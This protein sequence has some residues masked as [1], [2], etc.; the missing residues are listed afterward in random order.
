MSFIYTSSIEVA[1]PNPRGDPIINGNEDT[2]YTPSLKFPYS[3]TKK[4]AE[5]AVLHAQGEVLQNGGRLATCALRPMFIYGEG[6]P[7]LLHSMVKGI[8]NS[9][10]MHR[11]SLPE[12]RVNPVYVG[13]VALCHLLAA[14]GLRDPQR[15]ATIGGNVYFI[16][17]D[18]PPVSY[19]DFNHAVMSSLGFRI[20]EKPFLPLR[21][22]YLLCF[23][24]E[25]LQMLLRPVKRFV[26]PLNRQLLTMVNTPFSFSYHKAQRDLGY[27]PRFDW[28]E[29][30]KRTADWL[31]SQLPKEK[32][33]IKAK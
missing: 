10:V 28:A 17:D 4:E 13:N 3:R 21:L 1:G 18:T 30:R 11:F 8:Q 5:Q 19:S 24:M 9:G 33:K 23:L 32:A 6:S 26:P 15:R 16:S 14:R 25:M 12:A 2:P 31:V 22:L 29:A 27:T 20:Q 7:D